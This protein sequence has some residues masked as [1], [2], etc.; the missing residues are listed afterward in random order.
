MQGNIAFLKGSFSFFFSPW[1]FVSEDRFSLSDSA[2]FPSFKC[3]QPIKWLLPVVTPMVM[4]VGLIH[5]VVG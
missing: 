3:Y 4:A 2:L 1:Y 5:Y